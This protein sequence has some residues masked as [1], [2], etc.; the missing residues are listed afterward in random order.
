MVKYFSENS[1]E[2]FFVK[3]INF[4]KYLSIDKKNRI[5]IEMTNKQIEIIN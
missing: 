4:F 3:T 1:L 2:I 5:C